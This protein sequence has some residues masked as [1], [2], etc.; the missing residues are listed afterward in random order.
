M[1]RCIL[2]VMDSAGVG[3]LPDAPAYGDSLEVNTIGNTARRLGGLALPTLASLGLGRLT[4]VRGCDPKPASTSRIAR[5]GEL[6]AGKDSVTG[7]WEMAGVVTESAFPTFPHGFP[8]EVVAAFTTICDGRAPLGNRAASGTEIIAE[9]GEEHLRTGR[10]ILYTSADS[11]FQVA[12]HEQVVGVEILYRWCEEARAMLD[13]PHRVNRVIARPFTGALGA[14]LRTASRRDFAVEPPM[15][16]LDRLAEAGIEAH[17]VGKVSDIFSGRGLCSS[18]RAGDN[19]EAMAATFSLLER[20][21]RGLIFTNLNDFDSKY[22]HRRDVRGYGEALER[23]DSQLPELLRLMRPED[24]AIITADHGCDPTAPGTDHT[25]EFAP[26][27]AFGAVEA[28][29]LGIVTGFSLVEKS[30]L[31]ALL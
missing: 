13:G 1:A 5:L 24:T 23:L 16:M 27:L 11:V 3:A 2:L 25:R 9:L 20:V 29:D 21:E 19:D 12:A 8:P 6:S 14:F 30:V 26:F 22:G 7:H 4:P 10:P 28:A 18:T 31:S 17:G 15:N